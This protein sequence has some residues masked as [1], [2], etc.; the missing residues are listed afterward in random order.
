MAISEL[1]TVMSTKGQ[2]ILPSA[3]RNRRRWT[4]GT[5]LIVEERADG[6]LLRP[7]P[8]IAPT[9]IEDVFASAGYTGPPR[10]IEEMELGVAEGARRSARD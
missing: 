5:R 2:V 1:T 3:V 6:V 4:P 7:A 9:R 10:T 8:L